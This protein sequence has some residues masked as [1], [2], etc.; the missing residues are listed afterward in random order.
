MNSFSYIFD[1]YLMQGQVL[2]SCFYIYVFFIFILYGQLCLHMWLRRAEC[3]CLFRFFRLESAYH[4]SCFFGLSSCFLFFSIYVSTH[5]ITKYCTSLER[6]KVIKCPK[7]VS[8]KKNNQSIFTFYILLNNNWSDH[9]KILHL[10]SPCVLIGPYSLSNPVLG[11]TVF[12]T[13]PCC[14]DLA[15]CDCVIFVLPICCH[16]DVVFLAPGRIVF[17]VTLVYILYTYRPYRG[18]IWAINW[19]LCL[20]CKSSILTFHMFYFTT[21]RCEIWALSNYL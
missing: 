11:G 18:G 2:L 21:K 8:N 15:V 20:S 6:A 14:L 10:L 9:V 1:A 12:L 19:G 17:S 13:E 7:K 3:W 4:I 5:Q 16:A